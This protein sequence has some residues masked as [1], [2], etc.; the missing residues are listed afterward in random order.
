[1]V[2][3]LGQIDLPSLNSEGPDQL[4]T[5]ITASFILLPAGFVVG[6]IGHMT[7]S[8]TIVAIGAGLILAG[9]AVFM[10]AVAQYG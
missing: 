2:A 4:R 10:V 3:L 1:V 8:R 7:G 9:S 5:L 6:V